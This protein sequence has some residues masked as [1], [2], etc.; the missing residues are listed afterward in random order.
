M[1]I[2]TFFAVSTF[3]LIIVFVAAE[4]ARLQLILIQIARMATVTVH[5]S[6]L[7]RQ[8]VFRVTVMIKLNLV[9]VL[10]FM[11]G[12]AFLSIPAAVNIIQAM[13]THTLP[14]GILEPIPHVTKLTIDVLVFTTQGEVINRI[15]IKARLLPALFNMTGFALLAQFSLM[16]ILLFVTTNTSRRSLAILFIQLMTGLAIQNSMPMLK[17]KIRIV[18]IE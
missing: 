15:M 3:V 14:G 9:P 17:L 12:L 8:A 6:M 18:V 4:T 5:L 13:T 16:Y 1:A 7:T 10:F 2:L 11:T